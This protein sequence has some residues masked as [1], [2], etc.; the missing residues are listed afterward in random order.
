M[1][2]FASPYEV[3][4]HQKNEPLCHIY[5]DKFISFCRRLFSKWKELDLT[6]NLTVVY[7]SRTYIRREDKNTADFMSSN[8]SPKCEST[9]HADADGRLYEDHYKIV[10][11]NETRSDWES[12]IPIMKREFV[13]WPKEVRWN[14]S[15]GNERIPSTATEGNVLESINITLN[16]LHLHYIDRDLH[17]TGNSIVVITSGNGVFEIDKNLASITKQRMMDNGIGSDMLSLSLPPLHIAPFFLYKEKGASSE[18]EQVGFDDWKVF[19]EIPHWMNL[20]FLSYG[21]DED[22]LL[23]KHYPSDVSDKKKEDG[24]DFQVWQTSNGFLNRTGSKSRNRVDN[25]NAESN[26]HPKHMISGRDFHNILQACRPRNRGEQLSALP[27]SLLTLMKKM[28]QNQ[29]QSQHQCF[30]HKLGHTS[31]KQTISHLSRGKCL[32]WGAVNFDSFAPNGMRDDASHTSYSGSLSSGGSLS[33]TLQQT[34]NHGHLQSSLSLESLGRE[35]KLTA[36]CMKDENSFKNFMVQYDKT[37]FSQSKNKH[38][39]PTQ[40]HGVLA[41]ASLRT[42]GIKAALEYYDDPKKEDEGESLGVVKTVSI[43]DNSIVIP[44]RFLAVS[45]LDSVAMPYSFDGRRPSQVRSS[46]VRIVPPETLPGNV[47]RPDNLLGSRRKSFSAM[48]DTFADHIGSM[49]SRSNKQ[50]RY[51]IS[52]TQHAHTPNIKPNRSEK[53]QQPQ[54]RRRRKHWVLN[55]FRQEDEDEVLAKR[56]HNRRRWSHVFPLG[57]EE[58]KRHA[59]PNWKSLCQPAILPITIDFLQSAQELQDKERFRIKQYSVTLPPMNETNYKSHRELL[60]ELVAQRIIQDYQIV[61]RAIIS[62]SHGNATDILEQTLSMGHKIQQLSYNPTMDSIDVIQYLANFAE[63]DTPQI[64]RYCIWSTLKQVSLLLTSLTQLCFDCLTQYAMYKQDYVNV[65]QTF[66][67][68][69]NPYKWNEVDMLISGDTNTQILEGM[70]NPRISFVII[71]DQFANAD[72]EKVY[73]DKFQS[74]VEYFIRLQK[75]ADSTKID[76]HMTDDTNPKT[77]LGY[78]RFIVDLRKRGDEKY[79]WMEI[80]HDSNC[81]TRRTFRI[82]IQWLVA[83]SAK[84]DQQ[85]QLLQRRCTQYGLKLVS[86]PHYSALRSCF[87]NPV[88]ILFSLIEHY[89]DFF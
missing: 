1:W 30:A 50:N 8:S 34:N 44:E 11:D 20:S 35:E 37:V 54:Y 58:F 55:P 18:E 6:H 16:L 3:R 9:V 72:E 43:K 59:G 46:T 52:S 28:L 70:R 19:F 87:L 85:A 14:L 71:P 86:V 47:F 80:V 45:P 89:L 76:V 51:K 63:N 88:S 12:L 69:F 36:D 42:S 64:Y 56:T 74:L 83:V 73:T 23:Y 10:I 38:R 53:V 62:S 27:V 79:E 57:E 5:F 68:Y 33:R 29:E 66:T 40:E 61:P 48:H 81:D 26:S 41:K 2:D 75:E 25:V 22:L 67:K 60:E 7:F 82:T 24:T 4:T 49:N 21:D 78:T 77:S 65:A 13:N 31:P 15:S 84:I 39:K 17:R 32:E